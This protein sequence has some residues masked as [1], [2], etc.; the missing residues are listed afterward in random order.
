MGKLT[1]EGAPG[2]LAQEN[3]PSK[4]TI[5]WYEI[6]SPPACK[7]CGDVIFW[8]PIEGQW[9]SFDPATLAR[10]ICKTTSMDDFEVLA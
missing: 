8:A 3:A 10:H 9:R 7:R 2:D 4:T 5:R 1:Q 6:W